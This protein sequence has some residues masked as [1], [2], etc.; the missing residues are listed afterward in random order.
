[1]FDTEVVCLT[2]IAV[3]F[4]RHHGGTFVG[5]RSSAVADEAE[6]LEGLRKRAIQRIVFE[7]CTTSTLC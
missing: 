4:P 1:M 3:Q 6:L 7:S 2:V 5:L